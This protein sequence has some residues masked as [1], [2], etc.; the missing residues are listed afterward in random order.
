MDQT[1]RPSELSL[2]QKAYLS[3]PYGF[4]KE[5]LQLP[6]MD[7]AERKKVGECRDADQLF[8]EIFENDAQKRVL[9]DLDP[10]NSKV[11]VRTCNGAGKTT[12]LIPAATFWFMSVHPRSKVVITSGV[13]RQVREQLFPALHVHQKRLAGWQWNDA[14][15]LAPNG[16]RCVGFTTR[17]GGHFE[18]WHGNKVELYDLLQNDGPLM[19][20]VDEAK[21]VLQQIFDAIERCTY[22]RILLASSCGAA[23]GAFH[24]A[25][26]KD[27]RFWKRHQLAASL[28]PHADHGKNKELILRRGRQDP[29]VKSKVDAEFMGAVDGALIQLEW[30]GRCNET[31]IA[32]QPGEP[33]YYLDF[34]RGGDE[35]VM[36]EAA[37]NR[38]RIVAAW[39][40]R[41]TMKACGEFIRLFRQ[42]G[43]SPEQVAMR[44]R[45]DNHG[46]GAVMIDRFWELGW[47]VIRDNAG[48]GA[49]NKED[50]FNHGAET[51][52]EGGKALEKGTWILPDDELLHAQLV[53]RKTKARS[54]GRIQLES[55][56]DMA[57]RGVGS[58]DRAD[59]ILGAIR[60][61]PATQPIQFAGTSGRDFSLLEQMHRQTSE[62]ATMAGSQC[63]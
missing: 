7:R 11:A 49:D 2:E 50:Y 5:F 21:S 26:H 4:A 31:A 62:N 23:L 47:N 41:D 19:I 54:D 29:L 8:Y 60:P 18:G 13:D 56:E 20:I 6:I 25:F 42:L 27:A 1:V 57:K 28:C 14:S 16:S 3:S 33:R 61:L 51:W 52:G 15:L 17:A 53:S 59:A 32:H 40:E 55:K 36:A 63:E 58:P 48:D 46:L 45:G 35:N 37:G 34:A 39:R 10:H 9:D 12:V 30:I 38:T 43:L 22:Q 24:T 44:V